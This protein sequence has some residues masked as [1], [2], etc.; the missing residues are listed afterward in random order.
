MAPDAAA[1]VRAEAWQNHH[2]A[3]V[4]EIPTFYGQCACQFGQC[5]HCAAGRHHA[6]THEHHGP[7]EHPASYL[8]GRRGLVL[9]EVWETGH[10][11]TWTCPCKTADHHRQAH[12]LRLF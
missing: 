3:T 6:C 1:W 11:H 4:D 2:R 8:T 12:Q 9:A 5:G 10:H 7:T